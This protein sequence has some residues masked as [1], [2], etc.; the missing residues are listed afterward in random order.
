MAGCC[1]CGGKLSVGQSGGNEARVWLKVWEL[2]VVRQGGLE[3][4]AWK[5]WLDAANVEA[6]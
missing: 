3:G 6:R 5:K 4:K 2:S 1:G